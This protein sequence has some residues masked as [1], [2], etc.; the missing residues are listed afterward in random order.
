MLYDYLKTLAPIE[1]KVNPFPDAEPAPARPKAAGRFEA[2][3]SLA[4][5]FTTIDG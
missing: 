2:A 1:N 3:N 4:R 5:R